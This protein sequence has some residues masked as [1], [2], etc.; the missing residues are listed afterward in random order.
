MFSLTT[1]RMKK[2][3]GFSFGQCAFRQFECLFQSENMSM[4]CVISVPLECY[5]VHGL[6]PANKLFSERVVNIDKKIETRVV[7]SSLRL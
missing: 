6:H 4:T 1:P 2:F 5:S 3:T 7:A